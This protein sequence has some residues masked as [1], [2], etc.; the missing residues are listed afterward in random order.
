MLFWSHINL[1]INYLSPIYTLKFANSKANFIASQ[2]L[3]KRMGEKTEK[4]RISN[5]FPP[6]FRSQRIHSIFQKWNSSS[7]V[8]WNQKQISYFYII[9]FFF[10]SFIHSSWISWYYLCFCVRMWFHGWWHTKL[11]TA[12]IFDNIIFII[13]SSCCFISIRMAEDW[14]LMAEQCIGGSVCVWLFCFLVTCLHI[15]T[16]LCSPKYATL[17]LSIRRISI[18]E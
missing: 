9:I 12:T 17:F 7:N 13:F 18:Y 5:F 10:R 8:R 14:T 15:K 2:Q 6:H 3:S 16:K 1:K 4:I 11:H